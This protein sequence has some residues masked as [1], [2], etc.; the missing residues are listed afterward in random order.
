MVVYI[1]RNKRT[2]SIMETTRTNKQKKLLS[3]ILAGILAAS[4]I[5]AVTV[6]ANAEEPDSTPQLIAAPDTATPDVPADYNLADSIQEGTILHCFSWKYSDVTKEL[7]RIAEAGFT[8]IQISPAQTDLLDMTGWYTEEGERLKGTPWYEIYCP[9]QLAFCDNGV[10]NHRQDLIELCEEADKYGI[11]IIMDV[12]GNHMMR[13]YHEDLSDELSK[14]EYWHDNNGKSVSNYSR[15]KNITFNN[16]G[17]LPD[18]NTENK[19]I[20]QLTVE[21]L[22]DL[23]S[24][25]VDGIRWDAAKHIALPSEGSDYWQVVTDTGLYNYG[26]VLTGPTDDNNHDEL[27]AEYAEYMSVT[28]SKYS[29]NLF[30]AFSMKKVPVSDGNWTSRGVTA[31]KLVYWGESHDT[32]SND[33]QYG[34]TNYMTQNVID[35]AYAVAAARADATSLYFSRP[36]STKKI[37]ILFGNKGSTH[38]VSPEVSAVNHFHNAMVGKKDCYAASD[39]HAV[40]TRENGGAVI[41]CG[42]EAGEV[43]VPNAG[44]YAVPGT[45]IDE[46]SGNTFVITKD[47]ITG[48]VGESGIAVLY[49]SP[50]LG[51]IYIE[52]DESVKF[53]AEKTITLRAVCLES[54]SYTLTHTKK[55]E[56]ISIETKDFADKDTVTIGKDSGLGSIFTLELNGK[57]A[58]GRELGESYTYYYSP[59]ERAEMP[60]SSYN[61]RSITFDNIN[62][63]WNDVYV[64]VSYTGDGGEIVNADFPGE[65]MTDAGNE[66]YTYVIPEKFK[67][68]RFELLN[69]TFS[70]GA[71]NVISEYKDIYYDLEDLPIRKMT[72]YYE[73]AGYYSDDYWH[74]YFMG[75]TMPETTR[76]PNKITFDNSKFRWSDVYVFLSENADESPDTPDNPGEKMTPAGDDFFTYKLSEKYKD[77]L[78]LYVTFTDG[79]GNI[80][81]DQLV[82]ISFDSSERRRFTTAYG[83]FGVAY[84]MPTAISWNT[85][86]EGILGD[87]NSDGKVT[88]KD[89]L[90]I[91]RYTVGMRTTGNNYLGN[92]NGDDD[93]TA[94]DAMLIQ[95]YTVNLSSNENVG[96]A[97][98]YSYD[99]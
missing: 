60:D 68:H 96:K 71:G 64:Y 7:Q 84:Q 16:V 88:S 38:F 12:V 52:G 44:G 19:Y 94:K 65:K 72:M 3:L 2:V 10:F 78:P 62:T 70:D 14:D 49:D 24:M 53:G 86:F 34:G 55:G 81:N 77:A 17:T 13:W 28:D 35:R 61:A 9:A 79:K 46:V 25:G 40:I 26:E 82:R 33:G 58:D 69:V 45:Y 29:E 43:T 57:T 89:A 47:T 37:D 41:V 54:A 85:N 27:M 51:R 4:S 63:L 11:N 90:Q 87:Y 30:G 93:L 76:E 48:T 36:D 21:Y 99:Y 73:S 92:V 56:V 80:I 39:N 91:L 8:S 23:K 97:I 75:R 5:S 42:D 74:S 67:E 98:I 59:E 6:T 1:Y 22:N 50:V 32:Y 20:Q 95:R 66:Y 15:R 18:L 83:A 31:D